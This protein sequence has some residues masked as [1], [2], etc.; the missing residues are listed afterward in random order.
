MAH[1]LSTTGAPSR[2]IFATHL[3][4]VS[5]KSSRLDRDQ[6]GPGKEAISE[7]DSLAATAG[8]LFGRAMLAS[9]H[10]LSETDRNYARRVELDVCDGS[11]IL[12]LRDRLR[13]WVGGRVA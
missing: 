8:G 9:A 12:R 13:R 2:F 11:D 3:Y 5:Y 4:I 10:R 6:D 7:L 1:G